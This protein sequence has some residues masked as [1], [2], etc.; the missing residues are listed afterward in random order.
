MRELADGIP[1]FH[2]TG[3]GRES[4]R[5]SEGAIDLSDWPDSAS[6]VVRNMSEEDFRGTFP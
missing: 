4:F 1:P 6:S 5:R 2:H 3:P